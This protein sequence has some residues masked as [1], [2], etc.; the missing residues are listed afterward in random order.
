MILLGRG[1]HLEPFP[2]R[3]QWEFP[4]KSPVIVV[5]RNHVRTDAQ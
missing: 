4:G 1:T 5:T 2:R 3:I